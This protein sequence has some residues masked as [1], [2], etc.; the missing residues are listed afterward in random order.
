MNS[1]HLRRWCNRRPGSIVTGAA[2]RHAA[3]DV[4][5]MITDEAGHAW[6]YTWTAGRRHGGGGA[7]SVGGAGSAGGV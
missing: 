1:R 7:G 6:W 3:L 4:D 5:E 2:A